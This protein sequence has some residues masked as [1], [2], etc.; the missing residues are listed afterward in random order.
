[1]KTY[2]LT[3]TSMLGILCLAFACSSQSEKSDLKV[4]GG[5]ERVFKAVG[6]SNPDHQAE[7]LK[8]GEVVVTFDL[9]P[10]KMS[11][12]LPS[13]P[14]L[15]TENNISFYNGWTETYDAAI[16]GGSFEPLMDRENRY[17]RMWIESQNEARI[18]VRFRGA[19]CNPDEKIAHTDVP[20]G[21]PY[22][23][24]DWMD[25]WYI[26]YPDGYHVRRSVI[27]T[28]YAPVSKPF[29]WDRDPP[30]Y[31]Y[32]FH[33]MLFQGD[34]GKLPEDDIQTKALTL[35]KMNGEHSTISYDPYPVHFEPDEEELYASF[36]EFWNANIFVVNT[37]SEYHPFTI[38]REEGVSLSPYAPER[39]TRKGIF[40]SW[41]Q[42]PNREEGYVGAALGHM[43]LRT[44][45]KKTQN[46]LSQIYL[47]GFTNSTEP[48][49]ELAPLAKSWLK[50]PELIFKKGIPSK[51]YGYDPAQRAYL[52]DLV[53]AGED[54]TFEI[55]ASEDS[56][57]I[58]PVFLINNWGKA[59]VVLE[60]NG[61]EMNRGA[62]YRFGHYDSLKVGDDMDWKDVL[63]VWIQT[64][65]L[66]P[67]EII[68]RQE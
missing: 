20:S 7:R 6:N 19:L 58:N 41:P 34:P 48:H 61:S 3:T 29:G 63:V 49:K 31:V 23:E 62:D 52:L 15:V 55:V 35:I 40:Q 60:L 16:G 5:E 54:V 38:G 44:F 66:D 67:V 39:E 56:P 26:I 68:I 28:Y 10:T 53:Q 42:E 46:T 11:F 18:V 50:A 37:K 59:D 1:M 8:R 57:V 24:G 21:S 51:S 17:N 4:V 22:G 45:Y 30:N 43:I 32:E 12:N 13:F 14:C 25:E 33:E 36:G 27:Y 2:V 9:L 65:S 64:K 47:S